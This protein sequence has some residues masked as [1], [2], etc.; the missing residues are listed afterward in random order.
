MLLNNKLIKEV[1]LMSKESNI[2]WI[3]WEPQEETLDA[4]K[5]SKMYDTIYKTSSTPTKVYM[6]TV[7]LKEG[8][9]DGVKDKTNKIIKET[10]IYKMGHYDGKKEGVAETSEKF[11]DKLRNQAMDFQQQKDMLEKNIKDLKDLMQEYE[12]YIQEKDVEFI[13]VLKELEEIKDKYGRVLNVLKK[14]I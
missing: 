2:N 5:I 10:P 4:E 8:I 1:G 9:K 3:Y 11:E 6:K 7:E 12:V 14:R 13:D